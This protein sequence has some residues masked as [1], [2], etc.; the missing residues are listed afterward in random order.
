MAINSCTLVGRLVKDPIMKS[1]GDNI[2]VCQF[3][4]AVD[5]KKRDTGTNFID[6]VAW[7]GL[8]ETISKYVKK[9]NLLGVS[10]SLDQQAWKN[11][12]G[13]TQTKIQVVVND[14]QFLT[15]KNENSSEEKTPSEEYNLF[16]GE[17]ISS[18]LVPF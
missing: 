2:A 3:T 1:V 5:K 12:E 14:A 7:K 4:L 8:A 11:K 9:G 15:P 16:G 10:G 6:C 13:N 18:D 17:D